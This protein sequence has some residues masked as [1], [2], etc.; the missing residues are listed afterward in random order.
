MVSG[1]KRHTG[2]FLF[3]FGIAQLVSIHHILAS[4]PAEKCFQMLVAIC[5]VRLPK[6]PQLD[7]II[8]ELKQPVNEPKL[9]FLCK[10]RMG[11]PL[12]GNQ[13]RTFLNAAA[14]EGF[15]LGTRPTLWGGRNCLQMQ[16]QEISDFCL[17]VYDYISF[18]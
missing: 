10:K 8:R 18:L 11:K 2:T 14:R 1:F 5:V 17:R 3:S 4:A 9:I 13:T 15:W 12:V 7:I 6:K 16:D